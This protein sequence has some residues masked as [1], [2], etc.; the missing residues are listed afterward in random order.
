[1]EPALGGEPLVVADYG[2][3]PGKNS[4]DPMRV[5]IRIL[6]EKVG[7]RRPIFVYHVDQPGDDFNSLFEALTADPQSYLARELNVFA[8]AMGKSLYEQVFPP[9]FVHVGW[10]SY[11]AMWLSAIPMP[12]PGHFMPC[13]A[14][15]GVREAF[16]HQAADDWEAFLAL[17]ADELR[18]GGRLVIV[19]NAANDEGDMGIEDFLNQVNTVLAGMVED[20]SIG[21]DERARM[22]VG[23]LARNRRDLTAPFEPGGEFRGLNLESCEVQAVEDAAWAEYEKDGNLEALVMKHTL[24]FRT[25]FGPSLTHGLR[26]AEDAERC[27]RFSDR[28]EAGL[29]EVH[30]K[31]PGP[32][33][34]FVETMVLAK[35]S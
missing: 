20:G 28:L 13:F 5:V 30:G 3:S 31:E 2:S 24:F 8:C 35:N 19:L 7:P 15:G 4:L 16:R 10:S 22:V 18:R 32:L 25:I 9:A 34:T 6:R 23:S 33:R 11:A 21:A 29:K 17:R 27:R 26:D 14:K 12:I 1:V